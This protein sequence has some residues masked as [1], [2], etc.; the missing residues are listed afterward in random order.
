MPAARRAHQSDWVDR[1]AGF[2]LISFGVVHLVL[3]W[4]CVQLAVGDRAGTPSTTGAV[5]ELAEKPFG[6]FLVWAVAVGLVVL[7]AWQ[8]LEAAVGNRDKEGAKRLGKRAINAGRAVVYGAIAAG[9]I[10]VATGSSGG[11]GSKQTDSWTAK[12]LSAPGGQVLVGLV[13]LGIIGVGVGLI[14]V[15]VRGKYLE[16]LQ[17]R[18]TRGTTGTAVKWL[19]GVGHI[20]K[21]LALGVVGGLFLYAAVTHEADKSGGLDQALRTMLDQPFG[22]FLLGA[23]GVGFAAYGVF[24]LVKARYLDR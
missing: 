3:G 20:A 4:L 15:A 10:S 22:P 24:C 17:S 6:K 2:G 9:A 18:A 23:V 1:L 5:Q 21:G 11:G 14:V 8:A 16:S 12:L 19:G 7:A 13:A